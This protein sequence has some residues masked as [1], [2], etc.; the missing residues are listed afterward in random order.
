MTQVTTALGIR[1]SFSSPYHHQ[2]VGLVERFNGTL[3]SMMKTL[4]EEQWKIWDKYIPYFCFA[5]R[6]V[7]QDSTGFSPFELLYTHKVKGPL[8][9]VKQQWMNENPGEKDVIQYVLDMRSRMKDMLDVA[10]NNI[11]KAQKEA[12]KV[13]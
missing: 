6:E 13:V 5:Y 1:Q 9:I 8:E 7:P 10:Q 12:E 2:T 4:D 11:E 3:K